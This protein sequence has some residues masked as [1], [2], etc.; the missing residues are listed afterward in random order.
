MS[1]APNAAHIEALRAGREA[2]PEVE[3]EKPEAL[4]DI[5]LHAF[6]RIADDPRALADL[7]P[8]KDDLR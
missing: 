6:T 4:G 3:V 8:E 1:A 5:L 7:L 2:S